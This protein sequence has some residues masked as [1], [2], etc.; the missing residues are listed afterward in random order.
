MG[1]SA[2]F[3]FGGISAPMMRLI[4]FPDRKVVG[5]SRR[6]TSSKTDFLTVNIYEKV[7]P[8]YIEGLEPNFA[9]VNPIITNQSPKITVSDQI[10]HFASPQNA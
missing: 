1:C 6:K 10:Q 9:K 8:E 5:A 4:R 7:C 2:D 3:R